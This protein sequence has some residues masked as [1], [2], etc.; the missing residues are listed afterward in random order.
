MQKEDDLT[1]PRLKWL[2]ITTKKTGE[3]K[4]M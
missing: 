1:P 3:K 4:K 2:R